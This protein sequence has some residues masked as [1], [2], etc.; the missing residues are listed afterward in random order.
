MKCILHQYIDNFIRYE[1][2]ATQGA[3]PWNKNKSR[4]EARL[5]RLCGSTLMAKA[6]WQV[7]VPNVLVTEKMLAMLERATEQPR[8]LERD[9]L[10]SI[11]TATECILT[12][13]ANLAETIQSHKATPTYQEHARKSGTQKNQSGLTAEELRAKEEKK[14]SWAYKK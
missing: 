11:T 1:A 5:H 3:Q 7:D 4:A 8:R 14:R 2:D 12:W 13:L 9:V 6:I 10:D